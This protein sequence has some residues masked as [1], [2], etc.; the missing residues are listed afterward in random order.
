MIK[1]VIL[2]K[3][4]FLVSDNEFNYYKDEE[5]SNLIL[6]ESLDF[7]ERLESLLKELTLLFDH[8]IDLVIYNTTHGGYIPIKCSENFE[9]IHLHNELETNN[10][11]L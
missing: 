8:K 3:E 10:T 2:N 9:K 7:H 4:E 5:F 11:I 6:V 1:S